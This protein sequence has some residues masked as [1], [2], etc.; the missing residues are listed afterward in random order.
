MKNGWKYLLVG[1]GILIIVFLI[2]LPFFGFGFFGPFGH[3][4]M[5]GPGMMR[6]YYYPRGF[7]F[8]NPL[9]AIGTFVIPLLLIVGV[10]ALVV[11]LVRGSSRPSGVTTPQPQPRT[12]PNCGK[13]AQADWK[14]CPYCGNALP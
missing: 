4:F 3:G 10:V 6:G 12:C 2:A 8:F 11:A 1:L 7:G 5:M 13:S 9:M 14:N